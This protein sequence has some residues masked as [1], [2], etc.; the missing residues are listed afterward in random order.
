MVIKSIAGTTEDF[1]KP[2]KKLSQTRVFRLRRINKK[3]PKESLLLTGY[4]NRYPKPIY[5]IQ[6][7]QKSLNTKLSLNES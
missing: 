4:T 3:E 7:N 5:A 6:K 1:T 2:E